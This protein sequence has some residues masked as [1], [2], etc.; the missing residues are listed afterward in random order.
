M[1]AMK[2]IYLTT[3]SPGYESLTE[4]MIRSSGVDD[5]EVIEETSEGD[6]GESNFNLLCNRRMQ[7]VFELV[8]AG[9]PVFVCDGDV[10]WL[11]PITELNVAGFDII[12]QHDPDSGLCAG[13]CHYAANNNVATVLSCVANFGADN[14]NVNDQIIL[15]HVL[16]QA[17]DYCKLGTFSNVLSW[18]LLR[19][20]ASLWDGQEF[21]LPL[22]CH[23]FHANFTIGKENKTKLL[24]YVR[25]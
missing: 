20:D 21:D 9:H 23:G 22:D 24:N 14:D 18:G 4:Q 13:V 17:P 16:K 10:I 12:A 11:K 25:G 1:I 19:N 6:F 15:N 2:T 5:W 7:R 8:A 3:T